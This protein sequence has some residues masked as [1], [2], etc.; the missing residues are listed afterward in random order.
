[1]KLAHNIVERIHPAVELTTL[2]TLDL[3]ELDLPSHLCHFQLHSKPCSP[4]TPVDPG[5]VNHKL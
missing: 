2:D 5:P 3:K 1:M 4:G